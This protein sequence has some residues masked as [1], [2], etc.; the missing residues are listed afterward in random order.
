MIHWKWNCAEGL[1]C[2][3]TQRDAVHANKHQR[4]YAGLCKGIAD[5]GV[6]GLAMAESTLNGGF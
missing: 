3:Y 5:I 2:T 4:L 1:D 6:D